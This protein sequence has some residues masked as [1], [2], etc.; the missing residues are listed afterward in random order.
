MAVVELDQSRVFGPDG[1]DP[2]G[3]SLP[4]GEICSPEP[5]LV[6]DRGDSGGEERELLRSGPSLPP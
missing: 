3:A 6:V 4:F 2:A 5:D 1:E